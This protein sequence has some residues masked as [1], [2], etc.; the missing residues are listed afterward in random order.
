M[1]LG[2]V[3]R[4]QSVFPNGRVYAYPDTGIAFSTRQLSDNGLTANDLDRHV[5]RL[6]GG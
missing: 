6:S 3:E 5:R 4:L 1:T 2:A